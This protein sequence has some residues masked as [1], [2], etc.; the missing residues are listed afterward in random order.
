MIRSMLLACL[1]FT[2]ARGADPYP[3]WRHAG[4]LYILTTPEGADL[5]P[6]AS[7]EGFPLLVR[8]H[9]DFFDFGQAEPRGEDIRFSTIAGDPLPYQIEEWDAARGSA[10]IWVRIPMIR[11]NACQEIR[12][13]WGHP[14]AA[15]ESKGSA[16][17]NG[18]NGFLSVW[19]MNDPVRDDVGTLVSTDAGTEDSAGVIGRARRFGEGKGIHCGESIAKYPS[20]ESPSSSSAWFR[21]EAVNTD[22]LAWGNEGGGTGT[23]VRMR[24]A[25]PP[26]IKVDSFFADVVGASRLAMNE[27]IHV[28]HTYRS[29][30]SRIYVNGRL[31]GA[32][33]P[34]FAIKETS[35][36]WIGGWYNRYSFAGDIDEVR[37]SGVARS[38]DWIRL[39]Y[40]N[41]KPCQTLVGHV[42]QPGD[43]FSV[44]PAE[45]ALKEGESV[46]VSGRAGGARKVTWILVRDGRETIVAADRF[47]FTF[48]AGRVVGDAK[49]V[50]RFKA[51][52][53]AGVRTIDIPI[54]IE[55]AIP[56]PVL[57]LEAP[58]EWN[59][60]DRIEVVPTIRNLDDLRAEG[61][62]DLAYDWTVSG[63]AVIKEIA[64][65]RLILERSQCSGTIT[66]TLA[67]DNGGADS[68]ASASIAVTEPES[69]PWV[70]RTPGKDER[71]EDGQ[72]FARDDRGEGALHWNGTLDGAADSVFLRIYAG[73]RLY[74]NVSR[75]PEAD[76]T[77]ALSA[78]LAP[79][80]VKYRAEL[81]SKSGERE[82]VLGT[83]ANLVCGD[84]YLIDGQSNAEA[85]DV[86]ETDPT[87]SSDWIR[88]FGSMARDP[89]GAR[90]KLWGNAVCRD[91]NGGKLQIGYWGLELARRL[92]ESQEIPICVINGAVGGTRID[93]HQRNPEDPEDA[94]TIYGRLLWRVR[95]ARLTHGIRG[96]IWHQGENDQGAD[97]PTGGFGWETYRQYFIDMSAGWKEDY[98]NLQHTYIFQIWPK[99]CAMGTDGS[100]DM[101][102]EVQRTLPSYYSN[103]SIMSTLGIKP[104][105]GCHFPVAGYAEFARLICPL[106]ERDIYGEDV[107]GSITPPNLR[108]ARYTTAASD[109]IA[110]EFDQPIAWTDPLKTE[111]YL[112][113][114]RGLVASGS[115]SG[116]TLVLTLKGASTAKT[117]TYIEGRSW[118]P[119]NILYGENGIA[120]LTFCAV[121]IEPPGA[122]SVG[123]RGADPAAIHPATERTAAIE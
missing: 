84:A 25:S 29:R 52:Y 54:A 97:G 59:G 51:V 70:P 104:P 22:I 49:L 119:D 1:A 117:I 56:E 58:A 55:E 63:G 107:A 121:P 120:A 91:R 44:S 106:I 118:N 10:G 92:V 79:G 114:V 60:R 39:E 41:Q 37:I 34:R 68:V 32:T 115:A 105:G 82:T 33:T 4:S 123:A 61:A 35:R 81:G 90:L 13:H 111:F 36:M 98:P 99:A 12:L 14:G 87:F 95:Q 73:D 62:A 67:V 31:D 110:L 6:T 19:H 43:E 42:V 50:L 38:A 86:G 83:A 64:P 30:D 26:H 108:R 69:D 21:A 65:D 96:I 28:V 9:R 53:A 109:A 72:F 27:W 23:K 88:S 48:D 77:Y 24:F 15:S 71:P 122:P 46:A 7:E 116:D 89:A 16:V 40:E 5:P 18:S 8:L 74:A 103:M 78:G 47:T 45:I 100:D 94:S 113:G 2:L 112:D 102:R 75:K 20:G 93:M 3:D 85:T 11:G 66:V 17:F 76:G 57:A 101:L 80:L